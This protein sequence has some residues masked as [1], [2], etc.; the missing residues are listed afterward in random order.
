LTNR[1]SLGQRL[2]EKPRDFVYNQVILTAQA[3]ARIEASS[4]IVL[5]VAALAALV[6]ANSPWDEAYFDLLHTQLSVDVDIVLLD[7]TLQHWINDG[8]MALFFF[9]MGLEIKRE[10]VHGE[11]ST[12][13]RALL[14]ATAALGGMVVPALIYTAF[15]AGGEGAH[16]WGIPIA[17]DIAFALGVLSLLSRRVPFSIRVF[18]LALAIADD[19]GGIVVIAVFY[20]SDIDFAW[21]GV[22]ALLLAI[23]YVLNRAG[24]RPLSVYVIMGMLLW[25]AVHESGIHATIA[26]VVLGLLTPAGPYYNP[27]TFAEDIEDLARRHRQSLQSGGTAV[28]QGVLRQLEDLVDG[29]QAPLER[30]EHAIV[31]WVSFMIVPI[32]ALANAGVAI[33]GDVASEALSSP[34]SQGVAVGLVVGK[35]I[36]VFLFTLL[37]VKLRLCDMPR[38]ATWSHIAGV[39]ALA[40]IGFTVSLLITD[41]SFRDNPILADEAKLGVLA[42]SIIAATLGTIFL[43]VSSKPGGREPEQAEEQ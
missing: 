40:G 7:L 17:T 29:T 11:L 18:L 24:V 14:P 2:I 20:T 33:S 15:N 16:G 30:I 21:M 23:T 4:G 1:K 36:G 12:P 26:G 19:I 41:L 43:L 28:Q 22:A 35:P 6:W 34:V 37:A 39:G 9:L 8:L 10:L 3:F 27:E 42:A 38:G 32:F 25:V 5:I 31:G 13:R